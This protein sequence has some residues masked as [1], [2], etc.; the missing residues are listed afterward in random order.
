MQNT[1]RLDL[2]LRTF[3]IVPFSE[4]AAASYA[5][6]KL[7]LATQGRIIGPMDMLIA[8]TAL[9]GGHTLVTNNTREY[10]RIPGLAL[11]NW[12]NP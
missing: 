6:I 8:A 1:Q 5:E 3:I 11:E 9:A 12:A 7:D 2:W 10:S 4:S